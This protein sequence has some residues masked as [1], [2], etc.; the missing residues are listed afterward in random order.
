MSDLSK[1][2]NADLWREKRKTGFPLTLPEYGD[3]VFI[4]PMNA[5]FFFKAGRIPD[6]LGQTVQDILNGKS[7][8]MPTPPEQSLEDTQ[9]FVLFLDDLVRYALVSPKVVDSPQDGADEISI[10]EIGYA[11]K[12]HIYLFFGR[13][14]QLLRD[15][16]P[17]QAQPV[18]A[19]DAPENNGA[20]AKRAP[21]RA[22]VGQPGPGDA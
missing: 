21:R 3:K 16:R 2:T 14:A 13:P 15:F 18:A 1:P 9:K 20:N 6:F 8:S 22:A 7:W 10:D 5:D 19:L 12:L 4:R 17:E 11:D